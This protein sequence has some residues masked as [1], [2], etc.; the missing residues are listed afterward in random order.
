M[1]FTIEAVKSFI[2]DLDSFHVKPPVVLK[3]ISALADYNVAFVSSNK[4][5]DFSAYQIPS[6]RIF[7]AEH[8]MEAWLFQ[9]VLRR[10]IKVCG[11]SRGQVVFLTADY[12]HS[13]Q[14]A[15]E[16][17]LGTILYA[18]KNNFDEHKLEIFQNMP[19]YII[20]SVS[21]LTDILNGQT[22]GHL[23]E[24]LAAEDSL[25]PIRPQNKTSYFFNIASSEHPGVPVIF[26]GRYFKTEDARYDLHP[27]SLRII[28][29]KNHPERQ[30]QYFSNIFAF[31]IMWHTGGNFDY[32]TV[33]PPKPNKPDRNSLYAQELYKSR[34][35]KEKGIESEVVN[36]DLLK[37]TRDYGSLKHSGGAAQ[38]A[39][40]I[41]GALQADKKVGGKRLVLLD[42]VYAT[43]STMNE[44]ISTLLE[45]GAAQVI[46]V[47]LAYHPLHCISLSKVDDS[48]PV[49]THCNGKLVARFNKTSGKVFYGCNNWQP[50]STHSM[51]NFV[52]VQRARLIAAE[53]LILTRDPEVN[54]G[55]V[56]F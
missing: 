13:L 12:K 22:V 17:L 26:G 31:M 33:V 49:C 41:K 36:L 20:H 54:A 14:A 45:A 6:N 24:A 7:S 29:A 50:G 23:A 5:N 30:A 3:L 39:E 40:R 55:D 16:L 35:F 32:V 48:L 42:D 47:V 18:T 8:D 51:K 53:S 15:Q 28:N 25:H 19:D 9:N 37:C 11:M 44:C 21:Q 52:D 1:F 46:P 43:G 10:A 2:V 38:R 56:P 27:L 4:S 34:A